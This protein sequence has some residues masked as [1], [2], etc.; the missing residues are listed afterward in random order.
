MTLR[1]G[2]LLCLLVASASGCSYEL[3]PPRRDSW[4]APLP[5]RAG[6]LELRQ[7]AEL[8]EGGVRVCLTLVNVGARPARVTPVAAEGNSFQE[9][10]T[11]TF[12]SRGR[13][14]VDPDLALHSVTMFPPPPPPGS[15]EPPKQTLR[16]GESAMNCHSIPLLKRY[17]VFTLLSKYQP[18][19]ADSSHAVEANPCR[20]LVPRRRVDCDVRAQR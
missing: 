15:S 4:L 11:F 2:S 5:R 10:S 18:Y 6:G 8:R 3:A 17:P 14:F 20:V 19:D 9:F 1:C 12:D 13:I 16:P 7:A